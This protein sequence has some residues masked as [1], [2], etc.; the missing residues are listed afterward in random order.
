MP[1]GYTQS[2]LSSA[3]ER[4]AGVIEMRERVEHDQATVVE[5][6]VDTYS[7]G[8]PHMVK[9]WVNRGKLLAFLRAE[10][11]EAGEKAHRLIHGLTG[12]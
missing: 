8:E 6:L 7:S 12:D 2:N 1:M 10:E 5:V 9:A 11:A 3:V 4:L